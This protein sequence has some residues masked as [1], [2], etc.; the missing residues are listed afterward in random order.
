MRHGDDREA[1][2]LGRPR[3][4]DRRRA[5]E[6]RR[7]GAEYELTGHKWFCSAPMCD[8]FLVLAQAEG[9]LSC[10]LLPR[11]DPAG[12]RNRF[13]IQ[14]LKD[15]LGNRS[16]RLERGRVPG[17]L[18]ADGRRGGPRGP[19]DH[20]DGQPHAA[21]LRDRAPG[22]HTRRG[23]A[24]GDPPRGPPLR[25]REAADR[26]AADAQRARRPGDRVRGGDDRARCGLR[27]PSTRRTPATS[28]R[29]SFAASPP[30]CSSTG[31][32]SARRF[33]RS[34]RSSAWAATATSRSP[35]CRASSARARSPR[36][37]RARATSSASTS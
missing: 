18:G 7:A 20:R 30:R 26:P 8:A 24:H 9:G 23:T 6:R 29:S 27:A 33:T 28:R 3:Q 16:E 32:A 11:F 35:G 25:V 10:F 21:R 37:G 2:R 12:E 17:C 4:H 15:K 22:R 5:A 34:R 31:A 13:H 14:R 19:D 36:S 1:G